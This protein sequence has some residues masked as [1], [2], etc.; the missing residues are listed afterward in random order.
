[1][2][3]L[4][5][6]PRKNSRLFPYNEAM[7]FEGTRI[8]YQMLEDRV[9][10]L[11]NAIMKLGFK[12]GD[13]LTILSENT[14]K[15]MEVYF[16]AGKL[17]MSVT[18]LNFRLADSEIIHI[19][20]DSESV[21]FMAGDGY[22]KRTADFKK[23]LGKIRQWISLDKKR[24]DF[25]F[26][27]ELIESS[28]PVDPL[29]DVDENEIAILMYT[30][31]TTGLP[32]G[33]MLSH[34]NLMTAAYSMIIA[35]G[36]TKKDI[37]CFVLPLFHI[38]LWPIP[39]VLMMGGKVVITR[40]PELLE[41]AKLI[42]DEKC[43]W[44][45]MVPTLYAWMINTPEIDK[46]D[47][48]SLRLMSY[49]GSP[50]APDVLKR[51]IERYGNIFLQGYGMTESAPAGTILYQDDHVLEGPVKLTRRLASAGRE[52]ILV[53]A[54]VVD[55]NDQEVKPGETGEI[56]LRGKSIMMGYWKNPELTKEA[57]RNGW[58]HSGD[59]ATI[60]ED[61]YVYMVDRKADMIV[62]GGENVYPKEVEDIL[63]QNPAVLEC[64]VVSAPDA[65]WGER[66]QAVV[67][68]R[69]GTS[70][71]PDEL[72]AHCKGKLAGYKCPKAIFIWD[73]IPKT[74]VGKILR[75]EVKKHFWKDSDRTIG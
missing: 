73:A 46:F 4:G 56:V 6:I 10:R 38:A 59:M 8:T 70:V 33:V 31:G 75:R 50:I 72:I 5:D 24:E 40:R 47:L 45:N 12:K 54:K 41:I 20:N 14:H 17:G 22:E 52:S 13:R 3:T 27:E 16:A 64:A 34:R 49:A 67:T 62:T 66:V 39:C 19:A 9:N 55:E 43:T 1:M 29:V 23:D 11:A 26:Y 37:S 61:G 65:K 57:L 69:E 28:S 7:V 60:D 53:E 42:Q 48:S 68:L 32:K 30:G 71:S 35:C 44:I 63:Y 18:P 58:Y 21:L 15:Y 36:V 51:L 74:T 2:Y 25:L